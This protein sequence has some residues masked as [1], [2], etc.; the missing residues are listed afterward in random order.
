M[1]GLEVPEGVISVGPY[2]ALEVAAIRALSS[3]TIS[4]CL[5]R[6]AKSSGV[7]RRLSGLSG[8]TSSFSNSSFTIPIFPFS[9]AIESGVWP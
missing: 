4:V 3:F 6:L 8:L 9:A 2:T 1:A 7:L 5:N